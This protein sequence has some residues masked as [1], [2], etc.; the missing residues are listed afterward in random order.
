MIPV[1][2]AQLQLLAPN[3][4]SNYRNGFAD[5]DKVLADYDINSTALHLAHFMAQILHESGGLTVLIENLDYRAERIREVWPSRFK[6]VED[7]KPFAHNPEAL[8]NKVYGGR[9]GNIQ[10]GDG[11]RFIG[12]GLLQITGRESY[13]RYGKAL[14]I[15]LAASPDLAFSA[16]WC[17]P[18]AA[19]E[20]YA[21]GCNAFAD[22]DDIRKVTRAI[23]G[24]YTG[25][26]SRKKWLARTRQV[27]MTSGVVEN[28]TIRAGSAGR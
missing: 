4:R 25:L 27:W 16:E 7:A 11:W 10:P 19:A 13:E 6:T 8:A 23:N 28:A 21:A 9:M 26:T 18:L 1:T 20:W 5:A 17:L 2:S 12:R 3:I 24:G 14:G 15:E 22:A